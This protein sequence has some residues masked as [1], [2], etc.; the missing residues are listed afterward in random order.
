LGTALSELTALRPPVLTPATTL[1]ILS[2][3]KTVDQPR[4]VTALR[5]AQRLAGR[6]IW[7]NPIPQR[8]WAYIRSIQAFTSLCPMVCC[9][10]LQELAAACRKLAARN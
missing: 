4:A 1:L 2:D 3:T 5:E 10:T 9:S 7:L 6:V 8:K